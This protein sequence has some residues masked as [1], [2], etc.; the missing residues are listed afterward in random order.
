MN[1][2]LSNLIVVAVVALAL[3]FFVG[4]RYAKSQIVVPVSGPNSRGNFSGV[5][6][7]PMMNAGNAPR[8]GG[9]A[10]IVAGEVLSK[11]EKSI[12]VK[13]ND[14]G[15]K[16]IFYSTSTQFMKTEAGAVS[17]IEV[18]KSVFVN[19]PANSDGTVTA[20]SIQLGRF[21]PPT[22]TPSANIKN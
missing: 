12:T 16:I 9:R 4:Q 7:R 10:G 20:E 11:D 19:G 13:L 22:T 17:D 5:G 6:G 1:K 18:G 21:M 2:S 14:G 15:S 3:G 8:F